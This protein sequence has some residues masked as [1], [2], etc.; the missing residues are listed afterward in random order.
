MKKRILSGLLLLAL[1]SSCAGGVRRQPD[2]TDSGTDASG[3]EAP[4]SE[5]ESS[6]AAFTGTDLEGNAV[7]SDII[8]SRSK[9]T[10]V[11]VWATYCG[12]CLE[13]MPGLGELAAEYDAREFQIVGIVSDVKEGEDQAL[14]ESLVR[15]TGANYLHLLRSDSIEHAI[16]GGVSAVPTTFFFNQEGKFLGGLVGSGEKSAWEE[17]IRGLLEEL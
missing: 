5:E 9:L 14:V 11:N 10:M 1:L 8:F 6:A 4:S 12:P 16:L 3:Q 7:A 13:E 15:E 17:I 2:G